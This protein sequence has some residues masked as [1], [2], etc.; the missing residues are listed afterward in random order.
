[1]KRFSLGFTL[2]EIL[3]VVSIIGILSSVLYA[4][5]R[6]SSAYTRDIERQANLRAVQAALE[7]YK[8]DHGRYPAGCNSLTDP[9]RNDLAGGW[10]GQYNSWFHCSDTNYGEVFSPAL[11]DTKNFIYDND[12]I[13]GL[14]PKYIKSLPVDPKL[15]LDYAGVGASKENISRGS[16]YVYRTNDEGTVYK[17]MAFLAVET[18][19]VFPDHEFKG[20]DTSFDPLDPES[21]ELADEVVCT[22]DTPPTIETGGGN[23]KCKASMCDLVYNGSSYAIPGECNWKEDAGPIFFDRVRKSYAVWGGYHSNKVPNLRERGT[24]AIVCSMPLEVG[25]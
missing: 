2:V 1:M 22:D 25:P 18:E 7:L 10:S 6:E 21:G 15:N 9:R 11:D 14:V 19:T 17:F 20:C 3:V 24:E 12:Y 13:P 4:N 8:L 16:G 5:F 23:T